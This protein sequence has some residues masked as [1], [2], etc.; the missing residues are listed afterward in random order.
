MD[1]TLLSSPTKSHS[2][3]KPNDIQDKSL[4][5]REFQEKKVKEKKNCEKK[6]HVEVDLGQPLL[7]ASPHPRPPSQFC[8]LA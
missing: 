5:P 3:L 6:V 7:V 8:I 2:S 4:V 1:R